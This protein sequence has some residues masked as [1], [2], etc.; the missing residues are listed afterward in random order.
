M[1]ENKRR[2][3]VYTI[4]SYLRAP[5]GT[6]RWE[7]TPGSGHYTTK[8]SI[9]VVKAERRTRREEGVEVYAT[10]MSE[11]GLPI[12]STPSNEEALAWLMVRNEADRQGQAL[13]K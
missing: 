6:N 12:R 8:S 2:P 7:V 5:R 4:V 9:W 13:V 3:M 11:E 10:E 1:D